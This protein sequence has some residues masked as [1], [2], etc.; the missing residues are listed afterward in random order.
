MLF[1]E[2]EHFYKNLLKRSVL[3]SQIQSPRNLVVKNLF[4]HNSRKN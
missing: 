2:V 1:F 4:F 3:K